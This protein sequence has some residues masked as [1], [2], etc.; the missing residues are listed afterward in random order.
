MRCSKITDQFIEG[1][2]KAELHLHIEGTLEPELMFALAERNRQ[3]LK[4]DSIEQL[5]KAYEFENLQS[6]L[7]L[8]YE[9]AAV[10]IHE[11]DFYDLAM[12]YFERAHEENIVHTEVFFDPQTHTA[13]GVDFKDVILGL[14]RAKID[15]EQKFGLSIYYLMCFLKHLSEEDAIETL[16]QSLEYKDLITGVGLDST[17]LGNPPSKFQKV[18]QMSREAGFHVV[19]HAGEEGPPEYVR[20]A[21]QVLKAERIDHGVRSVED[22]DLMEHLAKEQ[23]PLTLCPLSNCKLCVIDEMKKF[24]L[25]TLLDANICCTINSDDPSYFGGYINENYKC[26]ANALGLTI[27][28]LKTLAKNGFKASFAPETHKQK[29]LKKVDTYCENFTDTSQQ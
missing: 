21:L 20:D 24:P 2:P 8:Y 16:Q 4:F 17:E 10:L 11:N 5:R 6:F 22:N 28:N 13:R 25:H 19:S 14:T 3:K 15:A 27:E 12:A 7:D 1:L 9:G 23:I 18:I 29:W 26:I